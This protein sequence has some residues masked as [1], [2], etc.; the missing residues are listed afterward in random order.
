MP[1]NG[2][3]RSVAIVQLM[4]KEEPRPRT[5]GCKR[6]EGEAKGKQ[7]SGKRAVFET[8]EKHGRNRAAPDGEMNQKS[9]GGGVD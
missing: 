8:E 4:T 1:V 3:C 7:L 2:N 5:E 9:V 6:T